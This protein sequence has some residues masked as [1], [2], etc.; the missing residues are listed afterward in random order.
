MEFLFSLFYSKVRGIPP[1]T[2]CSSDILMRSPEQGKG[3]DVAGFYSSWTL[4]YICLASAESPS[5]EGAGE[6]LPLGP[7]NARAKATGRDPAPRGGGGEWVEGEA[8]GKIGMSII[9]NYIPTT[10]ITLSL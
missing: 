2:I 5:G 6:H 3:Y 4:H 9:W 8:K 1:I 7:V 10:L